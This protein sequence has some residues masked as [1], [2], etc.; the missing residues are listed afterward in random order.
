M[1][2]FCNKNTIVNIVHL[3]QWQANRDK[4]LQLAVNQWVGWRLQFEFGLQKAKLKWVD[5]TM[6]AISE[7]R[8]GQF[9]YFHLHQGILNSWSWATVGVEVT[10]QVKQDPCISS[11][12]AASLR[13]W[14]ELPFDMAK[15]ALSHRRPGIRTK[16]RQPDMV[17]HKHGDMCR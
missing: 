13:N 12:N 2:W 1:T 3:F 17:G 15:T 6:G 7:R 4:N 8:R 10:I 9:F 11:S 5:R 16:S 14:S